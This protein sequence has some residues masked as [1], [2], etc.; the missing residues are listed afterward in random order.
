MSRRSIVLVCMF[1]VSI[2][3]CFAQ[4]PAAVHAFVPGDGQAS[5]QEP[6]YFPAN[7]LGLPDSTARRSVP[8]ID[9]RQIASLG[10]GGEIVL[11][12]DAPIVDAE[13][14][15]FSVFENA[16]YYSIGPREL[17]YAEP[18]EVSVSRDGT[19]FVSFPF[20]TLTFVGCAGTRPTFGDQNPFDPH[21][22]GGNGFD[23]A[24]IGIDSVRFIRIRDVTMLAVGNPSHP[25]WDPTLSGFDL[26]AV[27]AIP[28][29][30]R[31]PSAVRDDD[32]P[33]LGSLDVSTATI[34]ML[35]HPNPAAGRVRVEHRGDVRRLRL[36]DMRG[37]IILDERPIAGSRST[38][39]DLSG[40]APGAY[41]VEAIDAEGAR[42]TTMLRVAE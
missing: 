6:E 35:V 42:A 37:R 25:F 19:A 5:G 24:A 8:A 11:R 2:A 32:S 13:G 17:I 3:Q 36:L 23:L 21:V 29:D 28:I 12:F 34:A 16:F 10:L 14:V 1:V 20:D 7:V 41:V 18:A 26:D 30:G 27:V 31:S 15:D 33:E 9:P 4:T 40:V 22:S 38:A 39:I